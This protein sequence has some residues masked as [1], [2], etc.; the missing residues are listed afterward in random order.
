MIV[1]NPNT[2]KLS[3]FEKS[4]RQD[5]KYNAILI[6]KKTKQIK[7]IPFGASDYEHYQDSTGLGLWSHKDH[8]DKKRRASYH[9]RHKGENKNKFSSGYFAWKYLW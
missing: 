9:S 7:R 1:D 6:N 2:Y 8:N 3:G 4:H 5:K